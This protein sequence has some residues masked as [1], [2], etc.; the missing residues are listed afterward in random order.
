MRMYIGRM[1][2]IYVDVELAER[3]KVEMLL[4]FKYS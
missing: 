2:V 3:K 1:Y 4:L